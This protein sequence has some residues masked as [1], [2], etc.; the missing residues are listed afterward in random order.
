MALEGGEVRINLTLSHKTLDQNKVWKYEIAVRNNADKKTSA[1]TAPMANAYANATVLEKIEKTK[2]R[3]FAN[4]KCYE[5]S[6]RF[7]YLNKKENDK[8]YQIPYVWLIFE[9]KKFQCVRVLPKH[10][11]WMG[12]TSS[13]KKPQKTPKLIAEKGSASNRLHS[14]VAT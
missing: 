3:H 8:F 5:T 11:F 1:A 2:P 12:K 9:L 4:R 14:S 7:L 6:L 13:P 10:V